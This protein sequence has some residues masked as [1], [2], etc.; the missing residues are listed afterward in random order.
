MLFKFSKKILGKTPF[1]D[2]AMSITVVGVGQI[3]LFAFCYQGIYG[4][5]ADLSTAGTFKASLYLFKIKILD[6]DSKIICSLISL[7]H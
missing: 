1:P 3:V 4:N 5:N 7:I 6:M 2:F